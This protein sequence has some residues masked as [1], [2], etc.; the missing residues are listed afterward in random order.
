[1]ILGLIMKVARFTMTSENMKNILLGLIFFGYA[2]FVGL[3]TYF[4]TEKLINDSSVTDVTFVEYNSNSTPLALTICPR[5]NNNGSGYKEQELKKYGL[6]AE[7]YLGTSIA[8]SWK[9]Y[10]AFIR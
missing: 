1:M 8:K 5:L 6:T 9:I 3:Q 10:L 2:I 4:C 7:S